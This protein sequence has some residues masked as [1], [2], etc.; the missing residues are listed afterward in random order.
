M[1]VKPAILGANVLMIGAAG[2]AF[3]QL[4]SAPANTELTR[5]KVK[6]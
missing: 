1:S 6:K 2:L 4:I 5:V 3:S